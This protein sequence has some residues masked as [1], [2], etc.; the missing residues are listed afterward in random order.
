MLDLA[1]AALALLITTLLFL[2]V[3]TWVHD[4]YTILGIWR[5]GHKR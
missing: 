2:G 1:W 4:G 5:A 3:T